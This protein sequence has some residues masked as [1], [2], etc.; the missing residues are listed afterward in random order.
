MK[1][2]H[3]AIQNVL[4]IREAQVPLQTPV[5]L[6]AGHNRNGKTSVAEAVRMALAG[7]ASARGVAL[8]KDLQA[9]VHEGAKAGSCEV[10]VDGKPVFVMLPT[11]K[12]TPPTEWVAPAA[13]PYVLD[14]PR[15]SSLE[16]N[17]RRA[18]LFQL[19][20]LRITPEVVLERLT[21][22]GVDGEKA[23]LV[24]PFLRA[25]FAEAC[26]EAKT[27]GTEAKGAWRALTGET[28]GAVKA[29]AWTA[30]KPE[31]D[32]KEADAAAARIEEL[33]GQIATANQELGRLQGAVS[34]QRQRQ[35]RVQELQAK[36]ETKPRVKAKLTKDEGE[37][38]DWQEKVARAEGSAPALKRM[39]CPCCSAMLVLADGKLAEAG[40]EVENPDAGKLAEYTK[41]R[42][43]MNSAVANG[44]RDLAAIEAAEAQL[45]DLQEDEGEAPKSTEV[46]AAQLKVHELRQQRGTAAS[47][48]EKIRHD[49]RAAAAADQATKL[50][51]E[52]HATVQAWDAIAEALAP[53]GIPGDMLNEA[54]EPFNARLKQTALD[55]EWDVVSVGG[56]M[57]IHAGRPYHLLSE[58]EKWRTDAMLAEAISYL[59]GVKL[60][61]LDRFDVLD[62]KG[63]DDLLTWLD[64]LATNG[65]IDTV[66]IFGT[67]KQPPT[68]LPA[69]ATPVWIEAGVAQLAEERLAA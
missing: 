39:P 9:L 56:D 59:S 22:R 50:A 28:Y 62:L 19:M 53:D 30:S 11:G 55:T 60:L 25:G 7:D 16:P 45:A 63:R 4:G 40:E 49:Q 2:T 29:A 6:F 8:K 27:K 10:T 61:L 14:A 36:V 31:V 23:K 47:L 37:L 41:A 46:D 32:A 24:L 44:R 57:G 33:D 69:T 43:L 65:E 35:Q 3:L 1:I 5:T 34:A 13:L 64:I 15:F 20:G 54:L 67:L 68:G 18:F 48:L 58:S 52:H 51:A 12:M 21:K 66:L 42:D 17:Q 38:A 26:K